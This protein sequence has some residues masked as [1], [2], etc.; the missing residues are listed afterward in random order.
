MFDIDIDVS[1]SEKGREICGV[2]LH[3][4]EAEKPPRSQQHPLRQQMSRQSRSLL[5]N[6][7]WLWFVE[8]KDE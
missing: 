5:Q 7:R 8:M 3:Q 2:A 4:H 1:E 6:H